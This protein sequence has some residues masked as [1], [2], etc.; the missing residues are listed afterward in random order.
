MEHCAMCT[1][2][3]KKKVPLQIECP[4]SFKENNTVVRFFRH[5][6]HAQREERKNNNLCMI[7][8]KSS[9]Y[10]SVENE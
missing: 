7:K 8:K 6:N 9:H 4:I 5:F 10:F 1:L 3:N 2:F